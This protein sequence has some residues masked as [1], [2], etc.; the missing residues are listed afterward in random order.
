MKFRLALI[1]FSIIILASC[2][3]DPVTP[4]TPPVKTIEELLTAKAWKAD[5][6][7]VQLS[8]NTTSYYKRGETTNTANYD[9]DSLKFNLD[10]TGIYYYLGSQYTTTWNFVNPEKSKMTIIL[11]YSTPL[12]NDLENINITETYFKYAQYSTAGGI[13]YLS[14]GTRVPN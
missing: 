7:R 14:S 8:N 5:E 11:N 6:I 1:A 2:Q 4:D 12:T 3:K 9:S 13:S 10:N